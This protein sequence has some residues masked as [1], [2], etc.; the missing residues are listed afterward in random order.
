LVAGAIAY[1]VLFAMAVVVAYGIGFWLLVGAVATVVPITMAV[2]VANGIG[3]WLLV[4]LLMWF[5]L[6]WLL[7]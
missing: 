6:L 1:V 7:W 5:L 3:F 4:Q 2:V